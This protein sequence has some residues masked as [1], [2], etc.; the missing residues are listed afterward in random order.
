MD[1]ANLPLGIGWT[2]VSPVPVDFWGWL[3]KLV[4]WVLTGVAVTLGAP[5]WFDLLR[6]LLSL[7]GSGGDGGNAGNAGN[8]GSAPAKMEKTQPAFEIKAA[9]S[10]P[11]KESAG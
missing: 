3:I 4:G 8:A 9:S 11:S 7:K 1:V 2:S 10:D 6:K 5:F